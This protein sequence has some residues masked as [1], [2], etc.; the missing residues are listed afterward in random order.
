MP[1]ERILQNGGVTRLSKTRHPETP[2]GTSPIPSGARARRTLQKCRP[3]T[4][5][6]GIQI[7]CPFLSLAKARL[8]R[9]DGIG[10]LH[11]CGAPRAH[12]RCSCTQCPNL[13]GVRPPGR[14]IRPP[15]RSVTR[16]QRLRFSG[17]T[18]PC[19]TIAPV[20]PISGAS[21]SRSRRS[22]PFRLFTTSTGD[23]FPTSKGRS[24]ATGRAHGSQPLDR[25][26]PSTGWY[27]H[28]HRHDAF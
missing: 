12:A 1:I 5:F 8:S 27:R 15:A 14:W 24:S 4:V 18:P 2:Q 26:V 19:T 3:P 10:R 6:P 22:T 7:P 23:R 9:S 20:A 16:S 11:D 17:P 13:T 28:P 25:I 21:R